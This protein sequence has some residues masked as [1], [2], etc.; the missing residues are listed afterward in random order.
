[1]DDNMRAELC[2]RT[3]DSVVAAYPALVPNIPAGPTEPRWKS[4]AF[5]RA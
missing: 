4:K 5:V 3:L 1:M 2:V